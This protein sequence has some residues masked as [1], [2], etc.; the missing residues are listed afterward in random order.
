MTPTR[1]APAIS[2]V[3]PTFERPSACRRAVQ[4]ALDQTLAPVEILVC[5]DGSTDKTQSLF[6][7]WARREPRL[8]YLR[9]SENTG[10]PGPPRNHGLHHARGDWVAFLDDDD[11]WLPEKLE[12]QAAY[13]SSSRWD[14]V[15]GN[16]WRS[17]GGLYFPD[18]DVPA[19]P[20]R[21]QILR[22][23]P[24]ITS[25]AVARTR[26]LLAAG[27]FSTAR[28]LGG[29]EDYFMWMR[30]AD[31]GARFLIRPE[32]VAVYASQPDGRISARMHQFNVVIESLLRV[33]HDPFD[34]QRAGAVPTHV[35]R[36]LKVAG[37]A[38]LERLSSLHA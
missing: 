6:E 26:L 25:T 27:G 34:V 9:L 11:R 17:T 4:S 30:L 19:E 18:L 38:G 16:A 37:R 31:L 22:N 8:R 2:V 15:A 21:K 14:V 29:I 12:R 32:A 1:D 13:L 7:D 35:W 28:R 20:S 24:V 3:V 36:L 5:D 33:A 10:T 23:N